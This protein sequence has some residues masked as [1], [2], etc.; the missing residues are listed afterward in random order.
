[1]KV[2]S[3]KGTECQAEAIRTPGGNGLFASQPAT[4]S[5]IPTRVAVIA[6]R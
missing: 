6:R 1:M 3:C 5:Q 4:T 2:T